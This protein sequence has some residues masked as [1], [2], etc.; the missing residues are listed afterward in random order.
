MIINERVCEGCGDCGAKSGCLAV[1][2][3]ETEFGR[4][5][6]VNQTACNK[7]LSCLEGD[8]PSF[9]TVIAPAAE[10]AAVRRPEVELPPAPVRTD[11]DDVRVRVVG[12]GGGGVLTVSQV[13]QM[14]SLLE[15]MHTMGV[16]QTGLSQ[17]AGPVVSDLRF[18]STPGQEGVTVP[19]GRVDVLLGCD[20]VG[21]VTPA[22]L[23][24]ADPERT[25]AVISDGLVP[26]GR[27]I[28]D[29]TAQAPSVSAARAAI[30][31]VTRDAENVYLDAQR[32]ADELLEDSTPANVV[33]LGAALQQG[34]LPVS[35]AAVEEAFKLNAVG[36]ERNL[37]ALAWGRAWVAAPDAV[38]AALNGQS[39]PAPPSARARELVE[40]RRSGAPGSG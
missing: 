8:C 6:Q 4:K 21:T 32:I 9:I 23:R 1:E 27:M 5:T 2:P 10:R 20:V 39:A 3:V 12:V 26:T 33:V 30:D 24:G 7:D 28:V 15:G 31:Q 17:K 36:L 22:M 35:V 25:V 11:R 19:D 18:T 38:L 16:G 14:A 37:A 13:L 34:L 29:V 40:D